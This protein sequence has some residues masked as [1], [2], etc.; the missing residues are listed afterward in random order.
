MEDKKSYYA[1]IPAD[2]RYN[3]NLPANAKLLYGEITAL[4]N[5]KG[6]CWAS[7]DYFAELYGVSK[8]SVSKWINS[9]IFEGYIIRNFMYKEGTKEILGRC[10]TLVNDVVNKSLSTPLR[11]V[12]DPPKEKFKENNTY[13]NTFNITVKNNDLD[14][15]QEKTFTVDMQNKIL[16]WLTYKQERKETYK[17]TGFKNFL[18][19]VE[20]K[21]KIYNESDVIKL[22][23]ECMAN[24]W[25]GII[26]D[27]LKNQKQ[28]S[29][30]FLDM[31]EGKNG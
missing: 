5:E 12:K 14:I 4:C 26:W 8:I 15:F 24:G 1:I 10:I 7:N 13:N 6:F 2:V 22:F 3:K 19:E 27:K 21:L 30:P 17:P 18:S 11:K 28:S 31:L 9:L 29:N 16:E 25:K 23:S 20:N